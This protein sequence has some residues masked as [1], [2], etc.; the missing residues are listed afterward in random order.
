MD[1]V[2]PPWNWRAIRSMRLNWTVAE[3]AVYLIA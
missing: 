3:K 1:A 2:G